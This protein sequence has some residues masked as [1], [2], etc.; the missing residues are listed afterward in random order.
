MPPTTTT[1]STTSTTTTSSTTACITHPEAGT[2]CGFINPEDPCAPQPKGYGPVP[3]PDTVSAF[4]S[5]SAYHAAA[6]AA[7]SSVSASASGYT[8]TKSFT[9]LD[10]SVNA[11]GYLGLYDLESYN[12]TQCAEK[13]DGTA[14][15][16]A[17]NLYVERDPSLNPSANDTTAP[18]VWGRWCPDPASTIN[19]KCALWEGP[20][21]GSQATNMGQTHELFQV[22]ITGSDGYNAV[23]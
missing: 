5:Y 13:C 16:A 15:C 14:N 3:S 8:Y 9:D 11:P 1:Q 20:I 7:P 23:L 19:Y 4:M 2:Y 10:G 12:A 6:S 22:V 21:E 18:T 17:F